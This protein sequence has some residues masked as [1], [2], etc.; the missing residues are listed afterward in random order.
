MPGDVVK[1]VDVGDNANNHLPLLDVAIIGV[2]KST[3]VTLINTAMTSV[4][5]EDLV[6]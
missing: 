3:N 6:Y 1:Q 2:Y 5:L 4:R